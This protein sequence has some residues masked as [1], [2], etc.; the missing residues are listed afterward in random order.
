MNSLLDLKD[1]FIAAHGYPR[2]W[3]G[4]GRSGA[5]ANERKTFCN[6]MPFS[7][8]EGILCPAGLRPRLKSVINN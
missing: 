6:K 4:D 1:V 3:F 2:R 8:A 7:L 5:S